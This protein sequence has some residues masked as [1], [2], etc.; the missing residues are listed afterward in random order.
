MA[1]QAAGGAVSTIRRDRITTRQLGEIH[2]HSLLRAMLIDGELDGLQSSPERKKTGCI[3]SSLLPGV[4]FFQAGPTQYR[5][6]IVGG[7]IDQGLTVCQAPLRPTFCSALP[8]HRIGGAL[9]PSPLERRTVCGPAAGHAKANNNEEECKS[10]QS[11]CS[12]WAE[13]R[14]AA[15]DDLQSAGLASHASDGGTGKQSFFSVKWTLAYQRIMKKRT[16]VFK[17]GT[18]M[19]NVAASFLP[20]A[21]GTPV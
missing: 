11:L 10:P 21:D 5:P 20:Q 14:H 19:L 6:D 7:R 1:S 16:A 15:P 13:N 12:V 17:P 9:Q 4:L 8:H 2:P 18:V 3:Q